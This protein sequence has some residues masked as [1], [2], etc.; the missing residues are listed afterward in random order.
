[1]GE[2]HLQTTAVI[3]VKRLDSAHGRLVGAV[4]EPERRRLAESMF[5][6]TLA[7]IRR[8]RTIGRT[9]IVTADEAV[10][11]HSRWLG[12]EVLMQDED[13]GHSEAASAGARA[14]HASGAER[15]VMLPTDCPL[16]DPA[17]LDRH[18]GESPRTILIVPDADGSG[19]NALSIC[20]PD[21]F[22][23]AFGPDSCA[24][25][26]ARARAGGTAFSLERI[27]SL[28]HDLD[29]PEDMVTLRDAL[30]LDPEPA[31]R[32]ARVLWELGAVAESESPAAV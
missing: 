6:D 15:V 12:H 26:V 24:R 23:P 10:A 8:C 18:L 1:M 9:I 32:T 17:E 20:P 31:P 30:L 5:Q 14:A 27:E 29:T 28:A 25:H 11:R 22:V 7:K 3:P 19:T 4:E 2:H 16:L 13:H 21:A